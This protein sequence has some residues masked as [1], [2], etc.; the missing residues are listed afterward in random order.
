[1]TAKGFVMAMKGKVVLRRENPGMLRSLTKAWFLVSRS[2]PEGQLLLIGW[3]GR[4]AGSALP[5]TVPRLTLVG[6]QSV[7][8]SG[9]TARFDLL[10]EVPAGIS[11]AGRLVPTTGRALL[12]NVHSPYALRVVANLPNGLCCRIAITRCPWVGEVIAGDR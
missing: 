7:F 4:E 9:A 3:A 6:R 8:R 2:G 11:V 5:R 12:S 10:P 1:M